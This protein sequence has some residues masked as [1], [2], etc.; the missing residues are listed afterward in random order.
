MTG[1]G[2]ADAGRVKRREPALHEAGS[3][4]GGERIGI[5]SPLG[6]LWQL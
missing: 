3:R 1:F 6:P 2:A 4:S 5:Q